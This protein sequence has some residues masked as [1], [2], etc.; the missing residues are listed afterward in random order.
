MMAA[1]SS[2]G[3]KPV[4]ETHRHK[5]YI[6]CLILT[7]I[8]FEIDTVKIHNCVTW[9]IK[10]FSF[11]FVTKVKCRSEVMHSSLRRNS[12]EGRTGFGR[13][14]HTSVKIKTWSELVTL[15]ACNFFTGHF[16]QGNY[17][18]RLFFMQNN[19]DLFKLVL[20]R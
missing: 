13:S 16:I 1:S 2:G 15:W 17:Y 20:N 14:K 8:W 5:N 7:W 18:H 12:F 10:Y 6:R 4:C 9:Q 11:E 3:W 19:I